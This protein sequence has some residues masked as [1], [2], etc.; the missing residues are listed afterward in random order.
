MNSRERV[1]AALEHRVPDKVPVDFGGHLTARRASGRTAFPGKAR[2]RGLA[3]AP[4]PAQPG[5]ARYAIMPVAM[6]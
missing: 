6:W 3:A 1:R 5:Y 2:R 4:G